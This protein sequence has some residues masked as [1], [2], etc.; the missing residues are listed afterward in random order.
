MTTVRIKARSEP[1]ITPELLETIKARDN[2]YKEYQKIRTK[3]EINSNTKLNSFLASLKQQCNKL[4]NKAI[5]MTKSAKKNYINDKIEENANKPHELWKLLNDQLSGCSQ[6]VKTRLANINIKVD[7]ILITDTLEVAK[8]F[9]T[10]FT[11][12]ATTLVSKLPPHS[13]RFGAEHIKNYYKKL[14]VQKDDFKLEMVTPTEVFKKL[15]TLHLHKA[16]G[17]DTIPPRFLRDSAPT[18]T[19]IITHIIN[20]SIQH[21]QVPED[22]KLARVTPIHKKGSTLEP[23]NYRPVSILSS[24]SKVMERLVYEQVEK[25]LA[26]KNLMY[27]FQSGFRT[28][29]STDTCLLYLTDCIKYEVDAGKYCGMPHD[30]AGPSEGV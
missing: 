28:N 2:K 6:K 10:Y 3:T 7:N 9:N 4:R 21:G 18:I 20:L 30:H 1:W 15:S 24:I 22:F 17:L 16:T 25:Y 11:E 26:T 23:G 27:Q 19:P 29:H 5:S 8:R 13:G 14:G 12:I